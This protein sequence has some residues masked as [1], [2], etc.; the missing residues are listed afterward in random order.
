M[1]E[2]YYVV[3]FGDD[4]MAIA[5]IGPLAGIDAAEQAA[6]FYHTRRPEGAVGPSEIVPAKEMQLDFIP[7][8][9]TIN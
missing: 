9:I 3:F 8:T 1:T 5:A 6:I 2:Q 4:D 7:S